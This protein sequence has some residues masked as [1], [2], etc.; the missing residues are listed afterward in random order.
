VRD[1]QA[2]KLGQFVVEHGDLRLVLLDLL[3]SLSPV[4]RLGDDLDLTGCLERTYHSIAI[5][6]VVV[7]DDH[8]HP[9]V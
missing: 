7:G 6:R 4:L 2:V 9:L 1:R 8:T 3:Q 5:E